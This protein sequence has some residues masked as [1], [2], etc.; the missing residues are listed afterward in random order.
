MTEPNRAPTPSLLHSMRQLSA[1]ALGMLHT[2]LSLAGI[3]LEEEIQRLLGVLLMALA[4]LLFVAMALV[5]F[6]FLI[7]FAVA[8]EYRV[9]T[10]AILTTIYVL[11]GAAFGWRV[12]A[13]LLLRPPI[14]SETLAEFEKDR[15]ALKPPLG[16]LD[17]DETAR[18]RF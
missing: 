13:T 2:R 17:A 14:F 4:A 7:V 8:P 11:I 9:M 18:S 10:M 16:P 12:N 5:V 1:T 3:E 6:T 15:A